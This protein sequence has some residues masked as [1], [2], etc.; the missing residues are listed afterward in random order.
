M[1]ALLLAIIYLA[2]VSLGLPDSLIGSGWPIM[3]QDLGVPTSYAGIVTMI[4]A[5][6]TIVS[7]LMSD[8][9]TRRFGTGMVTA[10]S[11]AMTAGA[12]IGFSQSTSFWMLLVWAIPYGLGAGAVDAALN[13][14]VALHY[15]SRHMSWLHACWGVGAAISPFIMGFALSRG[16]D[17]SLG[18]LIVGIIQIVLTIALFV[19]IPLWKKVNGPAGSGPADDQTEDESPSKPLSIKG[20]LEIPGVAMMLTAFFAYCAFEG[21]TFLWTATYFV[22]QKG[23]APATAA[24]FGS[25]YL[26]GITAGRF[27]SGVIADRAGDRGM[28]KYG[29]LLMLVGVAFIALPVGGYVL[30]LAGLLIAGLGSAPVYPSIIHSTPTNFGA[31]NSHAI[32]GIQMA[33]AYAG[34]TFMPPLFGLLASALGFWLFPLVLGALVVLLLVMT[35]LLNKVVDEHKEA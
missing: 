6:G 29:A 31:K 26:I 8:R 14:Y 15:S 4:I 21:V 2:F 18:Y 9:L 25:L 33:S 1:Y 5:G 17:W 24:T 13:N 34:A 22:D 30:T 7:S 12:L 3:H 11:V 16:D 32:I 23:V 28:I 10:V 27:L 19:G 20:A 35:Q